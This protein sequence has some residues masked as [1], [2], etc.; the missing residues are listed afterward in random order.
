MSEP[1]KYFRTKLDKTLEEHLSQFEYWDEIQ[2]LE[3]DLAF[4]AYL[5]NSYISQIAPTE[6]K[7]IF[8]LMEQ[9][10]I[11]GLAVECHE[12]WECLEYLKKNYTLEQIRDG[13]VHKAHKKAGAEFKDVSA[14][15]KARFKEYSLYQF[16]Y[17]KQLDK[18]SPPK[19]AFLLVTPFLEIFG[20]AYKIEMTV[21]HLDYLINEFGKH[22]DSIMSE[23][24]SEK[25]LENALK[26]F[27]KNG[28]QYKDKSKILERAKEFLEHHI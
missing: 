23:K 20:E 13:T 14:H 12:K 11:L 9:G 19:Y 18:K 7:T 27:E 2:P 5:C 26:F 10:G 22:K 6:V 15:A 17:Q 8:G 3:V 4:E 28:Y 24:C 16:L 25:D 21:E 1:K